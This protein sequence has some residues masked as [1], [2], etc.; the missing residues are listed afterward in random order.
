MESDKGTADIFA[1]VSGVLV[2]L[3]KVGDT[4]KVNDVLLEIDTE[5]KPQGS[6]QSTKQ[7]TKK[8]ETEVKSIKEAV[9]EQKQPQKV[10]PVVLEPVKK[11]EV[12]Q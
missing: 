11:L 6:E 5:A 1:P 8:S 12:V 4:L 10:E 2:R 7:E 9:K 3:P